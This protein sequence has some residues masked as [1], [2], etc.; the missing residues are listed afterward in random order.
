MLVVVVI[1][2]A[3]AYFSGILAT[4]RLG[5]RLASFVGLLEV[6]FAVLIAWW[7]LGEVPTVLQGVGG[8]LIIAGIVLVRLE[9]RPTIDAVE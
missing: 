5:S 4:A 6:L 3:F 1:A 7:L 2:T 8:A 9:Q